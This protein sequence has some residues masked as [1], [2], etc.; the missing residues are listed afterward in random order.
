MNNTNLQSSTSFY[1]NVYLHAPTLITNNKKLLHKGYLLSNTM[2][3]L[4]LTNL[5]YSKQKVTCEIS[6]LFRYVI[7]IVT[8]LKRSHT[9][10][11]YVEM[12]YY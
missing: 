8:N 1:L 2:G 4:T 3:R 12:V 9:F 6:I 5:P 10:D 11:L 7:K